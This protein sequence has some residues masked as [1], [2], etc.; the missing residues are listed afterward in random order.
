MSFIVSKLFVPIKTAE[1]IWQDE[2]PFSLLINDFFCKR[3]D[4]VKA[5]E[6]FI[7]GNK[8]IQRWLNLNEN[9]SFV[10]AETRFGSAVNFLLIWNLW[11]K[12][13]PKTARLHY[14]SSEISPLK[15]DDLK[16]C[17]ALWPELAE[18]ANSLLAAYPSL[19]PG[20]HYLQFEH[21]RVN[22]T[23]MLGDAESC[24]K[25]Q[26][27]CG[28]PKLES[29]LRFSFVDAWFLNGSNFGQTESV[30][31]LHTI[32]LLSH[33]GS[34][35]VTSSTTTAEQTIKAAGFQIKK[36]KDQLQAE[37]NQHSF[38]FNNKR[39][40][41]WHASHPNKIKVRKAIVIGGGLAGCYTAHALAKRGWQVSLLDKY[42]A[43][44]QGASGNRQ[45]LLYPKLSAYESPLNV[46]MLTAF[47]FAIRAYSALLKINNIGKLSGL[48]QLAYNEK[49]RVSQADLQQW[50]VNYPELASL[51]TTE[52]ISELA[53]I[54]I[55]NSGLLIPHSGWLDS[56]ALCQ[57]LKQTPGI[58]WR[59]DTKVTE[60]IRI[61]N[62]WQIAG[63]KAD[64][65]V[66]ANGYQAANF[67]ESAHL[68][69]KAIRGQMTSIAATEESQQLKLPLCADGHVL[70][71]QNNMHAI[72]ASYHSGSSDKTIY[73]QD[74]ID[75]LHKLV[76][77][78]TEHCWSQEVKDNW[79]G[80][81]GATSDYLPL[82]GPAPIESDFKIQYASLASNAK[83][84]LP[85]SGSYYP[86]L[87]FCAAF[88]SRGLTTIPL[89]AEWLAA[90]I[91]NEPSF[92]PRTMIQSL[93]PARFLIK[94]VI[95]AKK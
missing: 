52:Q 81:R 91:N 68:L 35:L 95:R 48:I 27:I 41:P 50:L 3:D 9:V 29:Q 34:T 20:Y 71:A 45:A 49:E 36:D 25:E 23:L 60:L 51:K 72:G 66:L 10:I 77:M 53:G 15:P 61:D 16:R 76:K 44:G 33:P 31:L 39:R 12:Y 80:I 43:V 84:W 19:T 85:K 79:V 40:T 14:I 74:A 63:E 22:L 65:V 67:P 87:Y 5:K 30:D 24:F 58:N 17:L 11:L 73:T 6:C 70:P 37:F 55:N 62:H 59:P 69:L 47:L 26:L 57:M 78:P 38:T 32:G 92:I 28:D 64:V 2:L 1:L 7:D 54:T 8:L 56:Q 86:G 94:T 75:N 4:L 93:S 89:S 18:Q 21:G 46:F 82:V 90:Q 83:R 13:A 42:P 88:G